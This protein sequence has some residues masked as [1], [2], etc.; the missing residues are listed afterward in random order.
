MTISRKVTLLNPNLTCLKRLLPEKIK[1]VF[2]APLKK[3][4]DLKLCSCNNLKYS[5]AGININL[6]CT[7][8]WVLQ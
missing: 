1:S 8:A 7:H 3:S 4:L 2:C 6:I 5:L